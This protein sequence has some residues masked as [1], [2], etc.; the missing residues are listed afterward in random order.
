MRCIDTELHQGELT[1]A[2]TTTT[3][4]WS[5]QFTLEFSKLGLQLSFADCQ[6]SRLGGRYRIGLKSARTQMERCIFVLLSPSH[7][8]LDLLDLKDRKED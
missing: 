7:L 8:G 2:A 5:Q 3:S 1:T 4:R 6:S